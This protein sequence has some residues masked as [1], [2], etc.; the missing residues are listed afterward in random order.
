MD[1]SLRK[2]FRATRQKRILKGIEYRVSC[3]IDQFFNSKKS[4]TIDTTAMVLMSL[5]ANV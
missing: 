1:I 5:L 4:T 2:K 3:K